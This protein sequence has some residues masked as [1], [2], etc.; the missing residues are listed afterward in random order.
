MIANGNY[1]PEIPFTDD[2]VLCLQKTF[3][4]M[5]SRRRSVG[6]KNSIDKIIY[7]VST[8]GVDLHVEATNN[9]RTKRA[10][11]GSIKGAII[12]SLRRRKNKSS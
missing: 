4:R 1:T 5:D 12:G 10:V 8:D 11:I 6:G 9:Q 7:E 3:R 2:E